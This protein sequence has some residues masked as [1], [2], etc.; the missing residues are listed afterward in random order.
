MM[1]TLRL[2]PAA[3]VMMMTMTPRAVLYVDITAEAIASI[4]STLY[5]G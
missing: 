1:T 2:T 3:Q 4:Q 5:L